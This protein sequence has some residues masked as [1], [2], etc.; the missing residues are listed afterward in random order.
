MTLAEVEA[1][2][3]QGLTFVQLLSPIAALGGPAAG[4]VGTIVGNIAGLAATLLPQIE[5][6]AT[7]IASGDTTKIK[8]LQ[9]QLQAQNAILAA[10]IDAS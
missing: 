8:A 7:I 2:L 4:S 9:V 6:D 10:Q 5:N 1:A 3:E